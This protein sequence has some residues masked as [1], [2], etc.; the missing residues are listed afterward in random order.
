V[1]KELTTQQATDRK[2]Q[3]SGDTLRRPDAFLDGFLCC[4][5]RLHLPDEFRQLFLAFCLSFGIDVPG[6][7]PAVDDGGVSA[8]PKVV[9]NLADAAR[10]GF[11]SLSFVGLKGAGGRFPGSISRFCR[12]GFLTNALINLCCRSPLHFVCNMGVD[13]QRGAAGHMADDSG[14]RLYIHPVLQGG[15]GE[16]MP[17]IMEADM[18]A[19]GAL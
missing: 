15:S 4:D 6:H 1:V 16:G 17:Q 11:A 13:I 10:A 7:A 14:E 12:W 5:F 18:L 8:L 19:L 3:V 9:V 2:N